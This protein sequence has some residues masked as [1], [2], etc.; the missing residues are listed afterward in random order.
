[1]RN[2][3]RCC[4]K[5]LLYESF[6]WHFEGFSISKTI[7]CIA[8]RV[9]ISLI[10]SLKSLHLS[11]DYRVG[12]LWFKNFVYWGKVAQN[13][14]QLFVFVLTEASVCASPFRQ[15]WF[16]CVS[17]DVSLCELNKWV[18]WRIASVRK[19]WPEHSR[20]EMF[21]GWWINLSL[22]KFSV[23]VGRNILIWV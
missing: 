10:F 5:W 9:H 1:M 16:I 21:D 20:T 14:W 13:Q 23:K 7:K 11:N 18:G 15:V 3:L 4:W 12:L 17:A 8:A 6:V 22:C 2:I 19:Q